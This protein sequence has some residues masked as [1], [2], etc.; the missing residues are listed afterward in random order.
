MKEGKF[1][2]KNSPKSQQHAIKTK[3]EPEVV[4]PKNELFMVGETKC[5]RATSFELL[6][7]NEHRKTV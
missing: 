2:C 1:Y 4:N 7:Q 3:Q 5:L 6:S